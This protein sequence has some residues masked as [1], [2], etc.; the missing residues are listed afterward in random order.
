MLVDNIG[1]SESNKLSQA[2]K[3]RCEPLVIYTL[4][5]IPPPMTY[6]KVMIN[7]RKLQPNVLIYHKHNHQ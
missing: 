4:C 3:L 2:P 5:R 7:S 6:R 1:K